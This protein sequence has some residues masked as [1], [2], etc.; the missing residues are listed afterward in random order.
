MN[1]GKAAKA[2]GISAK[3]IRYCEDTGLIRPATRTGAGYRH[4][5]YARKLVTV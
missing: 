5:S 4:P 2:S 3:M 1:I